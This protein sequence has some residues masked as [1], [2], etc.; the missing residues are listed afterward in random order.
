MGAKGQSE[1][2]ECQPEG[3]GGQLPGHS[4]Q[5]FGTK[6]FFIE[7][8]TNIEKQKYPLVAN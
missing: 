7:I 1:G 6:P 8:N 2:L 5:M 3:L 4:T